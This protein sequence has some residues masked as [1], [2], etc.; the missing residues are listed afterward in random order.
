MFNCLVWPLV[1]LGPNPYPTFFKCPFCLPGI[2]KFFCCTNHKNKTKQKNL[3]YGIQ[4]W[5]NILKNEKKNPVSWIGVFNLEVILSTFKDFHFHNSFPHNF[6]GL[7][8]EAKENV[9]LLCPRVENL[10]Y[11]WNNATFHFDFSTEI[12]LIKWLEVYRS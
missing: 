6:S 9:P 8:R 1:A 4:G 2:L 3:V 11:K 7:C 5:M 12:F 10:T